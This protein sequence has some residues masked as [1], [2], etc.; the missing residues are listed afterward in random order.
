[1]TRR[2]RLLQRSRRHPS[3]GQS[4][5]E[6]ALV[7][8]VFLLML[9]GL[10]DGAR[11]VFVSNAISNA[12]REGARTAAVEA[13][14]ISKGNTSCGKVGGPVCPADAATLRTHATT[15]ANQEMSPFGAVTNL[16]ISCDAT[17][18]PSGQWISGTAC[19]SSTAS[20]QLVSVRV[21]YAWAPITPIAGAIM[22]NLTASGS[23]TMVIN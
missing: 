9:F 7:L 19:T 10:F 21:T 8:P 16:Y 3:R 6:F 2:S 15:A 20:G 12:A 11:Y 4:L 1:M 14:W 17:T 22:G 18:P 13:S 23:A 5:V